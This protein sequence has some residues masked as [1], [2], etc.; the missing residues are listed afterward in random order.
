MVAE[1]LLDFRLLDFSFPPVRASSAMASLSIVEVYLPP[2]MM[3]Y[4]ANATAM[5][6]H[7]QIATFGAIAIEAVIIGGGRVA[8]GTRNLTTKGM[9]LLH[10]RDGNFL[11]FL[12]AVVP[13]QQRPQQQVNIEEDRPNM[14]RPATTTILQ[15]ATDYDHSSS[16]V[17]QQ[18]F[19]YI[20]NTRR[21]VH[22]VSIHSQSPHTVV[23]V[24]QRFSKNRPTTATKTQN[25]QTR[26]QKQSEREMEKGN[27]E[28]K[29]AR[30]RQ[31]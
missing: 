20:V 24:S 1:R 31:T 6:D 7:V 11:D 3:N 26:R 4:D 15:Q 27:G 29:G 14:P 2:P 17:Q 9:Q 16:N 25:R 10:D 18:L 30:V 23:T 19:G 22:T 5:H 12:A 13:Q 28:T 21:A 8:Q